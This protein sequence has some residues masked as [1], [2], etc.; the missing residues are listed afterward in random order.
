MLTMIDVGHNFQKQVYR[1]PYKGI[2]K[3]FACNL[4]V[5]LFTYI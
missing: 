2:A 1:W 5:S 4:I 3:D